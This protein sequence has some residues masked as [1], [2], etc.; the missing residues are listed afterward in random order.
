MIRTLIK[1]NNFNGKYVA[2]KGFDSTSVVSEGATPGE[3]YQKAVK[4]GFK[5][6]V[7]TFVPVKGMVQIY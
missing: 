6:P 1:N 2:M 5:N 7:V 3:A 4:K